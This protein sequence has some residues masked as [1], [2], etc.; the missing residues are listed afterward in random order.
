MGTHGLWSSGPLSDEES[1]VIDYYCRHFEVC[2]MR[3]TV[4]AKVAA[5]ETV[6]CQWDVPLSARTDSD[7]Q[8]VGNDFQESLK[9]HGVCWLSTTPMW[10]AENEKDERRNQSLV[11]SL[12][13]AH[14]SGKGYKAQLRKFMLVYR[15]TPHTVT[16]VSP[17]ELVMDCLMRTKLNCLERPGQ[18]DDN[19]LWHRTKAEVTTVLFSRKLIVQGWPKWA[20]VAVCLNFSGSLQ[21]YKSHAQYANIHART[22]AHAHVAYRTDTHTLQV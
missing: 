6:F 11:K 21:C 14:M 18:W 3:S 4:S 16:G 13:I 20:T 5:V 7:P 8:F 12:K 1:V 10:P 22:D 19:R 2:F 15:S 17:A 9:K